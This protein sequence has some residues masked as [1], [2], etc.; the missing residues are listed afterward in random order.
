MWKDLGLT[1]N[2]YSAFA[3]ALRLLCKPFVEHDK[4][5]TWRRVKA[6]A[7]IGVFSRSLNAYQ[8]QFVDKSSQKVYEKWAPTVGVKPDVEGIEED[9]QLLWATPRKRKRVVLYIHGKHKMLIWTNISLDLWIVGGG[10]VL[11]A[12][13]FGFTFWK[14][15][16]DELNKGGED[17]SVAFLEY[18][19]HAS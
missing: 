16:G 6:D 10:Y 5:R 13:P 2:C 14:L 18:G 12:V 3:Q 7:V 19:K 17:Y 1:N 9:A 8:I 4:V 15:V 11:P